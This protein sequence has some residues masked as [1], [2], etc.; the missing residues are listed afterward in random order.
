MPPTG[1]RECR[2]KLKKVKIISVEPLKVMSDANTKNN[3][4]EEI[5]PRYKL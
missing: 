4:C 5:I 3:N 1:K 2:W